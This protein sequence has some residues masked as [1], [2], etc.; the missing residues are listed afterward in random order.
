MYTRE[1][2]W[3]QQAAR[4]FKEVPLIGEWRASLVTFDK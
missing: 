1:E 4:L 3:K 2:T